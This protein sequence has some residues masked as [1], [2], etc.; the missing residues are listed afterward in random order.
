[1]EKKVEPFWVGLKGAGYQMH[2]EVIHHIY[3]ILFQ[4]PSIHLKSYPL[5]KHIELSLTSIPTTHDSALQTIIQR[6]LE[7]LSSMA[8]SPA[9]QDTSVPQGT[10]VTLTWSRSQSVLE[11]IKAKAHA[12]ARLTD[13]DARGAW[14]VIC[15]I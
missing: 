6:P 12:R 2:G 1:M 14:S 10:N 7:P 9:T 13:C 15:S 8:P 5:I 11:M 4:R 3:H